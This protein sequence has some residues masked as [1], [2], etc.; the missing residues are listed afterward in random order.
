MESGRLAGKDRKNKPGDGVCVGRCEGLEMSD[1]WAPVS[2]SV[3]MRGFE[4]TNTELDSQ[5]ITSTA[6]ETSLASAPWRDDGFILMSPIMYSLRK[7]L[8]SLNMMSIIV[9]QIDSGPC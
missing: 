4:M 3:R 9:E 5:I 1:G 2:Q 7:G 6:K 8:A